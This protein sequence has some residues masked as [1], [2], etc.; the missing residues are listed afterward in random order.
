MGYP[1]AGEYLGVENRNVTMIG[2]PFSAKKGY[3]VQRS[4]VVN[5]TSDDLEKMNMPHYFA[6]RTKKS[7]SLD[8]T[9][10]CVREMYK[11]SVMEEV[12]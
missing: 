7:T 2:K 4:S 5:Q 1:E 11:N 12:R 8:K 6:M 3:F 9:H 10:S